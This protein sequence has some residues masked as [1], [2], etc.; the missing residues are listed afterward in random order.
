M[1]GVLRAV[2]EQRT[3]EARGGERR[4]D[5]WIPDTPEEAVAAGITD[6][7]ALESID[8]YRTPRGFDEHSTNR[9][10]FTSNADILG[11]DA[12]HLADQLLTQP[13]QIIVGG[14]R[15][16]TKAYEDA[17]LLR[18]RAQNVEDFFVVDGAGHYDLYDRPAYVD[19][20]V[21]RLEVFFT[22]HLST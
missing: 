17:E 4:R 19:Q 13:L 12:F 3:R 2:G 21:D 7:D 8:F 11:F 5:G 9:L 14:R 6:R 20:A 15:G 1:A 16:S 18:G 22:R 10:P